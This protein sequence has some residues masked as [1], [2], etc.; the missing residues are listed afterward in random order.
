MAVK[1]WPDR[2]GT[3]ATD[4]GTKTLLASTETG[5]PRGAN[6]RQGFVSVNRPGS[7]YVDLMKF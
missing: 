6:S 7:P 4:T 2:D 5:V 3:D 1:S